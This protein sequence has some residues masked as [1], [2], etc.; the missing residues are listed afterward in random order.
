MLQEDI[1]KTND[2]FER[3]KERISNFSGEFEL[4][5][6]IFIARKSIL[7]IILFFILAFLGA[8]AYLRY[9]T[10]IFESNSV[11]QIETTNQ[12]SKL[13]NV[14][15]IAETDNGL[16]EGIELLKSKVFLKRVLSQLPL[17]AS[18]YAEGT[19]KNNELYTSSPYTV[20]YKIIN[21]KISGVKIYIDF[22]DS[23]H[24]TITYSLGAKKDSQQ[25][26]TTNKW[27]KLPEMDLF[28]SIRNFTEIANEQNVVK[29][30]A[31]K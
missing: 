3:Y 21:P 5:L 9:T 29:K 15:N 4:G 10:P 14:G 16:A 6:F 22:I 20:D 19:F 11:L 12:A 30:N 1:S 31:S 27:I 23:T 8:S 7:W 13:L 26:F 24:G 28:I 17:Q 25:N 2:N 18:Y